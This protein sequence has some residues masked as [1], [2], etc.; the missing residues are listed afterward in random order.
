MHKRGG[1][2]LVE[3][4]VIISVLSVLAMIT[5]VGY[6]TWHHSIADKSAQSDLSQAISSLTNYNNF[7]N[8]YP[9]NLAGTGFAGSPSVSLV[10]YT[11]ASTIGVYSGL[12]DDQNA[13]LF[14]NTCNANLSGTTNTACSFAGSKGGAKV[15]VQGTAS[16]N[17]IWNS[18]ICQSAGS[19]CG[20]TVQL[21]CGP[22]C[23]T[24]TT[25]MI[26]Q[27]LQQGGTF[28]VVVNGNTAALPEPN[29]QP[30]SLATRYCIE[31]RSGLY[32]DIVYYATSTVKTPTSGPC[33]NDPA[34]HYLP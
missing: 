16:S 4:I 24:A 6:G 18:P 7:K 21:T 32:A 12:S 11:N 17:V 30:N 33:P 5:V 26:T 19:G 2:T 25:K 8:G 3:I 27:F 1:F 23:D 29:V 28:P 10:L 31:A 20:S 14:L 15:H 9:P 22:A 13:Q 34:L